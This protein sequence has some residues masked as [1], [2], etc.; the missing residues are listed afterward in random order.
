VFVIGL[1]GISPNL[2]SGRQFD[3]IH[4]RPR[5]KIGF[6]RIYG[7]SRPISDRGC[8]T[9]SKQQWLGR[10]RVKQKKRDLFNE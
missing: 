2:T 10:E 5:G 6:F 8:P 1:D 3:R 9:G 7:K 4:M